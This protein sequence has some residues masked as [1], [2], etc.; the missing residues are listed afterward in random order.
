MKLLALLF[1]AWSSVAAASVPET[2]PVKMPEATTHPRVILSTG[3]LAGVRERAATLPWASA[4]ARSVLEKADSLA[5]EPLDIPHSEGQ[6]T[7]WYTCPDDGTTLKAESPT[8]H[9]CSTCGKTYSG[10][11]YD[12]VY[13]TK[14]HSHWLQG[15]EDLGYAYAL[16][17]KP[18]YAKRV[19]DILVEY[20]S[21]Y[22]D[23]ELHDIYGKK[24]TAKDR[25]FGQTLN[26][27]V[28]LCSMSLGYDIVFDAPEFS[29]EDHAIIESKLLRPMVADIRANPR[30]ISNWQTW[31]NAAVCGTGLL[32]GDREY[33]DWSINGPN[34]LLYQLNRG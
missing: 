26:S 29:S 21:F 24:G 11:P 9:V 23:L 27:A 28:A 34:G 32:L 22:G 30:G 2:V 10:P 33:V 17:P 7:H 5:A 12:A 31:H 13:V 16:D 14:R 1:I 6:W 25:L 15:I 8:T 19:R 3:D 20:A 18:A 4:I